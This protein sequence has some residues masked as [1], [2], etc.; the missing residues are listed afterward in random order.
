[1][2][3]VA[4]CIGDSKM[5][6]TGSFAELSELPLQ[7]HL[8]VGRRVLLAGRI[9]QA[10]NLARG[11]P[12]LLY[13]LF[14]PYFIVAFQHPHSGRL[15]RGAPRAQHAIPTAGLQGTRT[16]F[17]GR[18]GSDDVGNKPATSHERRA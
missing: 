5:A 14:S 10:R 16:L 15:S 7:R 13:K 11:I 3:F 9:R 12:R 1:M 18:P 6:R 17:A 2:K 4:E 8:V